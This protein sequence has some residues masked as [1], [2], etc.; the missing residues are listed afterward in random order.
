MFPQLVAKN[1]D[2]EA[3]GVRVVIFNKD[4]AED[5]DIHTDDRVEVRAGKKKLVA[6]VNITEFT[7]NYGEVGLFRE[8]W[9]EARVKSGAKIFFKPLPKPGSL[10]YIKKKLDGEELSKKEIYHIIRDAVNNTLSSV[11]LATFI[12]AVYTNG[13]TIKETAYLTKAMADFGEKLV[14]KGLVVD[15][16]SIGGVPNNRTTMIAVPILAVA[17]LKIPKLSSRAISSA[18]GTADTMEVLCN[19]SIPAKELKRVVNKVGACIAWGGAMKIAYADDE[20]I[21][22][23]HPMS[24]DPTP[25]LLSS[26]MAKKKAAGSNLLLVDIPFGSGSK[27]V[28]EGVAKMLSR[29]FKLLGAELGIEVHVVITDGSQPVGDGIGPALEARDVL[30]ILRREKGPKDLEKK[31]VFLAGKLLEMSGKAQKNQGTKLAQSILNSGKAYKKF[32]QI[33]GAQGGN[34]DVKQG[35]IKVGKFVYDYKSPKTGLISSIDNKLITKIARA[36]GVPKD[37]K[38]GVFLHRHVDEPVKKGEKLL[39]IYASVGYKLETAKAVLRQCRDVIL[40]N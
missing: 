20:L 19:V 5:F 26:I 38:A 30:K 23:R 34:P 33:V 4:F 27:I 16:H 17:G 29:Q 1:L 8:V 11:E 15:K 25:L 3:G 10:D 6:I 22:V 24:L 32:Q 36:A 9:E 39:T 28:H 12:S 40:V 21:R 2:L 31:S 35:D 18:A 13:M 37:K 7:I 14:F